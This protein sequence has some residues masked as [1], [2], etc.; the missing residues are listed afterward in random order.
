MLNGC[1]CNYMPFCVGRVDHDGVI[2]YGRSGVR[3]R[4]ERGINRARRLSSNVCTFRRSEPTRHSV[5]MAFTDEELDYLRSQPLARLATVAPDGQ[6]DVT[7]VALEVDG[8]TLW[9]CGTGEAVLRTRKIRNIT[10]GHR[11]VALVVDDLPSFEPFIARGIRIYGTAEDPIE[12]VG[13]VGPATTSGLRRRSRGAGTSRVLPSA[14]PGTRRAAP[15]ISAV[16]RTAPRPSGG[17]T[18]TAGGEFDGRPAASRRPPVSV[19]RQTVLTTSGHR[20]TSTPFGL[21]RVESAGVVRSR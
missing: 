2:R 18:R 10:A 12:R 21:G 5:G 8:T 9:V 3:L 19:Y 1:T 15:S 14:T 11:Q 7:P 13:M 16:R 4:R 20:H 6:P 17:R